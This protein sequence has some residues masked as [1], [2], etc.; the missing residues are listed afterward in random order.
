[1]VD[2]AEHSA[3]CNCVCVCVDLLSTGSNAACYIHT[4]I[5]TYLSTWLLCRFLIIIIITT[6]TTSTQTVQR[7]YTAYLLPFYGRRLVF[8]ILALYLPLDCFQR[9]D[10]FLIFIPFIC[11]LRYIYIYSHICI[12][13]AMHIDCCRFL[14]LH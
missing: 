7:L 9:P 12:Y 13:V 6:T 5:H 2:D 8:L 11:V 4:F 3:A 1:M 10:V 14:L